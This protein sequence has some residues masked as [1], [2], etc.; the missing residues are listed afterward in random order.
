MTIPLA[1][2]L[3]L[4]QLDFKFWYSL[5]ENQATELLAYLRN[6]LSILEKSCR[7]LSCFLAH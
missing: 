6:R 2:F 7:G 3:S 5:F 4:S 1:P